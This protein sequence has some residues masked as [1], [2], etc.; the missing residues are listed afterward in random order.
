MSLHG[1]PPYKGPPEVSLSVSISF[2]KATNWIKAHPQRPHFNPITSLKILSPNAVSFGGHLLGIIGGL[3]FGPFSW[4]STSSLTAAF[5]PFL[6]ITR[7]KDWFCCVYVFMSEG[8]VE[9]Q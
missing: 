6:K 4:R 5:S 8:I 2:Y 9:V 1:T 3:R 7:I